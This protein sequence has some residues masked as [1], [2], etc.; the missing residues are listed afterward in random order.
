LFGSSDAPTS[1]GADPIATANTMAA[2]VKQYGL[3]GVD[4]DYEVSKNML[5]Y[6]MIIREQ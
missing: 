5:V 3:D 6:S 1:S 4:V 2:W